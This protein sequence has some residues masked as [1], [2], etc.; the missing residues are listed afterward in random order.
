[1]ALTS[2]IDNYPGVS[3]GTDGYTLGET[4]RTGAES[5][6]AKTKFTEVLSVELRQAAAA[7]PHRPAEVVD[8]LSFFPSALAG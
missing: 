4:M 5:F 2:Q 3:A 7:H 1:M 8:R 6:G